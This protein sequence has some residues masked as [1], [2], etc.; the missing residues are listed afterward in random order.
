MAFILLAT[1][2]ACQSN[3]RVQNELSGATMGTRY[4]VSVVTRRRPPPA[5]LAEDIRQLLQTLNAEMSTYDP[6]SELSR[7]NRFASTAWFPVGDS[8]CFA[9][10]DA[11]A[12]SEL[13]D[14]AFD[15]TVG[16][17]V[18]LWG[19]GPDLPESDNIPAQ[20]DIDAAL[21]T[22]GFRK[23]HADCDNGRLR[24]DHAALYVDLSAYAKGLAADRI[25]ELLGKTGITDYLVEIGGEIR[26]AGLNVNAEKWRIAIEQPGSSEGKIPAVLRLEDIA[27]ATSG[28]YRNY[29]EIDGI[30]YSHTIDSH[31]GSPV[32]HDTAS[33]TVVTDSAARADGMA[34]ALLV[35]GEKQG[36]AFA[37]ARN[38]AALFI[39]RGETGFEYIPS[40]SMS[41]YLEH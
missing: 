36:L 2:G 17:V 6:E 25:G 40:V 5:T 3:D 1:V 9:V 35:M 39:I 28:D 41:L 29:I 12:I 32:K 22:A 30:R 10:A 18:N 20:T 26:A 16:R 24:K 38:I 21:E 8:L 31:T 19:F 23:L 14:G 11:L 15:I 34:T 13:T 7:F 4:A 33:V 27:V 37:E